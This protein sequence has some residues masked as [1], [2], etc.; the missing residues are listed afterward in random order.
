MAF[1]I[2]L[3]HFGIFKTTTFIFTPPHHLNKQQYPIITIRI[4]SSTATAQRG[5]TRPAS[6]PTQNVSAASPTALHPSTSI[7]NHSLRLI[8]IHSIHI[9]KKC[10]NKKTAYAVFKRIYSTCRL[11]K[12]HSNKDIHFHL[13]LQKFAVQFRLK[14]TVLFLN[15]PKY[16]GYSFH[17]S[18]LIS[19]SQE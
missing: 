16:N 1:A 18:T 7:S 19:H 15:F 12:C 10:A 17:F 11:R 4:A 5:R 14:Y 6:I 2:P 9:T 13:L 3:K 8:I